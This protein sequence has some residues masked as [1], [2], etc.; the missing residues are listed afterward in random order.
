[1]RRAVNDPACMPLYAQHQHQ[2]QEDQM[3]S[4]CRAGKSG[5]TRLTGRLLSRER[6]AMG[7]SLMQW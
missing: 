2:L 5:K 7:L 1:M 4:L 3:P 6:N